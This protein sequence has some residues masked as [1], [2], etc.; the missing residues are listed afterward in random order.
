MKILVI[1]NNQKWKSWDTK[2]Q[3]VKD[4]FKPAFDITF[5]LVHTKIKDIPFQSYGIFDGFE[6]YG[7]DK[8]WF[9]E[10]FTDKFPGYDIIMF[11]MSTKENKG[12]PVEGW[13]WNG[14]SVTIGANEKGSYNFKG[15]RYDG[16][17]WFNLARH[18]ICHAAYV[19][20]GKYDRTH[21]HWDSGDLSKVLP[22]LK[23]EQTPTVILKRNEDDGTQTLGEIMFNG[24]KLCTLELAY[25]DNKSNI[26]AIPKGTYDVKYTFSPK[27]M[28]YTYEVL[29]V[30]N[31]S[32]IR[33]HSGNY[34][35]QIQGCILLGN[36]YKDIN[37]DKKLDVVNS[38]LSINAFEKAM[39]Y[40]PFKLTIQ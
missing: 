30:P 37:G 7:V 27:F 3:E 36:G 19:Q 26:S 15:V 8:K 40:K 9:K 14:N 17:K 4:W 16:E 5:E 1:A 10:T 12:K 33:I 22:E 32:G 29:K 35:N 39:Q 20:Q 11:S 31:R 24:Q 23:L 2:L 28:R 34:F 13:Q 6:R 25:K 18:E 21:Y 38:K